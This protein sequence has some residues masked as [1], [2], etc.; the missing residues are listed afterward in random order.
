MLAGKSK[1]FM[2]KL[3][4]LLSTVLVACQPTPTLV[5]ASVAGIGVGIT[6]DS[7][8]SLGV[9][10]GQQVTWTN[11]DSHAHIVHDITDR[12]NP[13][14]SS[15][16]LQTGDHFEFTFMKPGT[17]TYACSADETMTGTITVE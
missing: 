6:S 9:E 15:G 17:Y 8:P 12:G 16:R 11:Q 7:C 2:I 3:V 14:F 10:V 4:L 13:H 1:A 5:P